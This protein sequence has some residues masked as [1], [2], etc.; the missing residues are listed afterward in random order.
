MRA[1]FDI[2]LRNAYTEVETHKA[3][4]KHNKGASNGFVKLRFEGIQ[5]GGLREGRV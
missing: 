1:V 2:A 3:A 4:V 5:V